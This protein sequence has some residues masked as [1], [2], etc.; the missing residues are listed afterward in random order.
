MEHQSLL[1]AVLRH[2]WI[3][4]SL[5][6]IGGILGALPAP[7]KVEQESFT[8]FT[9]T[10]TMLVNDEALASGGY[11]ISPSQ[12]I[13]FAKVGDVPRRAAEEIGFAG[14]PAL[15]ASEVEVTFDSSTGALSVTTTQG[16]AE[17]A[18]M[19]ADVFAE[20]LNT[21][22]AERQDD[23]YQKRVAA[24]LE[25]LEN[26]QVQLDEIS[27]QLAVDPENATLKAQRDAVSRQY[28]VAFEQNQVLAEQPA[29]LSFT[30]LESAQAIPVEDHGGF[31]TPRS[32]VSRGLM[33]VV[34]GAALGVGVALLLGRVDRR[35]RTREQAEA[36]LD[37][38]AR[39]FIPKV[40][41]ERRSLVVVNERHDAL[42]DSY[43][44]VRN[45]VQ[46][47]HAGLDPVS[48]GRIT[49]VVS[50]GPGEGKTSLTANLAAAF[51]ESGHRSVLVNTDFRRPRLAGAVTSSPPPPL[52]FILG[53]LDR[54]D[55]TWLL[56]ETLR[57]D[58]LLL[59][60]STLD[61]S[62]G[63]LARASARLVPRLARV[64]DEVVIDTSPVAST[65]EVLELVPLADVIVIAV[66]LGHTPID[67]AE[68][69]IATL[70]DI[71]SA[72]IVLVLTGAEK[73][74]SV[75]Y[76]YADRRRPERRQSTYTGPER[77]RTGNRTGSPADRRPIEAVETSD[78][79]SPTGE[80]ERR[81]SASGRTTG[82]GAAAKPS[83]NGKAAKARDAGDSPP[84]DTTEPVT[85]VEQID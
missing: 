7:E 48:R 73:E 45:I 11:G 17:Q 13:L 34:A 67:A 72:P 20:V 27:D 19:V 15:L 24:S 37:L 60:L 14:S 47:I 75:Y 79:E 78:P 64:C 28:S 32:R 41:D 18:V 6:L 81:P 58:L 82:N 77:R 42:S 50:P 9:A 46:F 56:T 76:E 25:R 3:V 84:A 52:P 83:A 51:V 57:P 69:T 62:A 68:R 16:S 66:K 43:R 54:V 30:T 71:T 49:V 35:I 1:S 31:S 63:E 8:N 80:V 12:V 29:S 10:H 36:L 22:L 85:Q 39:A 53:D 40:K 59:D 44:T 4:L 61:G 2:W 38:R 70:R 26:L 21:Y 74:K 55:P 5:A 65:A 23:L 33:G